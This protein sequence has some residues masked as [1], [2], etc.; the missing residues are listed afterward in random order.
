MIDRFVLMKT[1][2]IL[3]L[4]CRQYFRRYDLNEE[5]KRLSKMVNEFKHYCAREPFIYDILDKD[6]FKLNET[7]IKKVKN[8]LYGKDLEWF[9]NIG[10]Y[11][12]YNY[13]QWIKNFTLNTNNSFFYAEIENFIEN[14]WKAF[15]NFEE[16]ANESRKTLPH[17]KK[18]L[19]E[20]TNNC[21]LN[22]IMCGIGK[23]GYD[24]SRNFPLN[25][26]SNLCE[27]TFKKTELIRLNGLGESTIL[28]NFSDY[29]NILDKLPAQLEIVT[30]LTVNN[31]KI[32]D[33]L[34]EKN[35]NFLISCDSSSPQL[36]EAIRRGANFKT[37]RNNLSYIRGNISNP[38][39]AQLIF[40]LMEMNIHELSKVVQLAV[41]SNIGGVIINIVKS[42][43]NEWMSLKYEEII[44]EFEKAH[45]ISQSSGLKLKLPDH[46]GKTPINKQISNRSC[47]FSCKN[48]W[49]E[50]YIRY[51]G[52][53]TVCNMLNP[54]I[55]GNC[56]NQPFMEIWNGLNPNL[57][58]TFV[59]TKYR[60]Y[61]CKECYY[62]V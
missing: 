26:L 25:L 43:D 30:N 27:N 47:Q 5:S 12:F 60:H 7:M 50:V 55:Y 22:C 44:M 9:F 54:Y 15:L 39:H 3:D 58:R 29:L 48:P 57:F 36:F 41:D 14:W 20:L 56:Q 51:N 35:T 19:L 16:L 53:L 45:Q 24:S 1:K 11:L 18:I 17:P 61:Y 40:T 59:N 13:W 37:F 28:P 46:L 32:W 10:Q 2:D 31:N 6:F 23:N 52:D 34:I 8:I 42:D 38:I 49:E 4:S 21:N 62:L 33:Q